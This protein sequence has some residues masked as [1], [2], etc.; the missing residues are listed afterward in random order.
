MA[1]LK[2]AVVALD[3]LVSGGK[4]GKSPVDDIVKSN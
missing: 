1:F 4:N 2:N 3:K